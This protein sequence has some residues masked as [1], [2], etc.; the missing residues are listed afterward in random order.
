MPINSVKMV[1][2]S[3]SGLIPVKSLTAAISKVYNILADMDR[4]L[5]CGRATT[6]WAIRHLSMQSPAEIDI[7]P[8]NP[9]KLA[10]P[11]K[12][13]SLSVNGMNSLIKAA[14]RPR[15]FTD[16]MLESVREFVRL[17]DQKNIDDIS[18]YNGAKSIR[19]DSKIIGNVDALVARRREKP[20]SAIDGRLDMINIHSDLKVG[21]YRLVDD[22]QII[23]EFDEVEKMK[24]KVK[25]LLGKRVYV[26]GVLK[27]NKDGEPTSI[28]IKH[29]EAMP[30]DGDLPKLSD[31]FGL[32]RDFTGGLSVDEF[33]R[34]QR[35]EG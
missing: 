29:M 18:L 21:I 16:S 35:G 20:I 28:M 5:S 9:T 32:D 34:R 6:G 14:K 25:E 23:A 24:E 1:I 31:L 22:R 7:V 33:L 3:P 4:Q 26:E 11:E 8:Y 2:S 17:V 10:D 30:D 27:R 12:C 19:L 15:Y 13:I